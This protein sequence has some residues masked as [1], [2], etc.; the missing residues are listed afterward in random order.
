MTIQFAREKL[1]ETLAPRYGRSESASI[2]R[3]VFEDVF[4]GLH[5]MQDD[6]MTQSELIE[7]QTIETRLMQGEPL[8]YVLGQADFFG[9]KFKVSPAVLIPRQ[10]TEE[11]VAWVL[12]YLKT[13]RK[14]G[15]ALLDIGTGSGC[16]AL[17]LKKKLPHLSVTA[18][19][20]SS[21]ALE[22]TKENQLALLGKNTEGMELR[23]ADVLQENNWANLPEFDVVVSNPP[24][25]P[26]SEKHL[27][28]DHVQ[29]HEPALALFVETENPLLF[30]DKIVEFSKIKLKKGGALFFECNEFNAPSVKK[31]LEEKGYRQVQLRQDISGADRMVMGLLNGG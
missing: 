11:L 15:Q 17:T 27:V 2:A 7:F 20:V 4:D 25:I 9:L 18:L 19:D 10:E 21:L 26:L 24:Y 3:I 12:E 16:I 5:R 23:L 13:E 30:Y 6:Q 1:V 29:A 14:P 8:Q 31:L 28:P 22:I